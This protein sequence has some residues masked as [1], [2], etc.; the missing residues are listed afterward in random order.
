[1]NI[2]G[3]SLQDFRLAIKVLI[4]NGA[5]DSVIRTLQDQ[6]AFPQFSEFLLLEDKQ[7]HWS[8]G[9]ALGSAFM[10]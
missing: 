3:F 8:K 6:F 1:M 5:G 7:G 4:Y 10:L 9:K 2:V